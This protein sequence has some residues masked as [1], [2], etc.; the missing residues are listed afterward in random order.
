MTRISALGHHQPEHVLTNED[1]AAMVDTNDE[2][3]RRRTGIVTRRI[4]REETVADLA[5]AAA[6][7]ALAAAGLAPEEIGMV[8]VASC[9]V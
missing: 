5:A 2:W 1:L 3:I 6:G 8:T 4:A 9:C 7:K